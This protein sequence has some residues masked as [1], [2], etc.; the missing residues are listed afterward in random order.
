MFG[1]FIYTCDRSIEV[2][3]ETKKYIEATKYAEEIEILGWAYH[4][5]GDIIPHTNE[6]L[7][8]G[9]FFPWQESWDE[10]QISFN[11]CLFGL[12]KQAMVSLRSG[13]EVG[14]LSVYWNLH[15]DGH[16]V[17]REWLVSQQ[18]T[19]RFSEI[20]KRLERHNNFRIF[21]QT[22]DVKSRLLS[23]GY[24]HDY[25]HTKGF[26]YSNQMGI[27]KSNFQTFE[28][29]GFNTWFESFREVIQVLAILH[30]VKY[31]LGVIRY[32]YK[33]KFGIY[34]PM[35]G[36]LETFE[37]DRLEQV[38]GRE[39]FNAIENMAKSDTAVQDILEWVSSFPDMTEE[40]MQEQI[41]E[42]DKQMIER[43]G[44]EKWLEQEKMLMGDRFAQSEAHKRKVQYLIEWAQE[45]GFDKPAWKR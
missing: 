10:L 28:E 1:P 36:G 11:L 21:Q 45:N 18:D 43:Q 13:L 4:S 12:Y 37:I 26:K 17:I 44:L 40:D 42:F 7:F 32:D 5:I 31:P 19:P 23:L 34:K 30:L 24:L 27:M 16:I 41:V 9:H 8:S 25:V 20:W 15:D 3:N 33:K 38:I 2:Y 22:Y 6:N 35:F 29:R 39:A 14:L